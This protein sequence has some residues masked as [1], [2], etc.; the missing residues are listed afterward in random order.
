M[1]SWSS[2]SISAAIWHTHHIT[3]A[4]SHR[5]DCLRFI[6]SILEKDKCAGFSVL[7]F[8]CELCCVFTM[9]TFNREDI[10]GFVGA[11]KIK[12][13]VFN[14][15]QKTWCLGSDHWGLNKQSTHSPRSSLHHLPVFTQVHLQRCDV[16]MLHSYLTVLWHNNSCFHSLFYLAKGSLHGWNVSQLK[17]KRPLFFMAKSFKM[18]SIGLHL[19]HC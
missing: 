3:N 9:T 1:N 8:N 2:H 17:C 16:W 5:P 7:K 15:C 14:I 12:H 13:C 10:S 6:W 11:N 4:G 18:T 19:V